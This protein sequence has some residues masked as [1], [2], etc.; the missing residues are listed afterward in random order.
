M[1]YFIFN[2]TLRKGLYI[3]YGIFRT[4]KIKSSNVTRQY[5]KHI[6]RQ[7]NYYYSNPDI[8]VTKQNEDVVLIFSEDFKKSINEELKN[9]NITKQPRKN[10]VGLIAGVITASPCF[11]QDKTNDWLLIEIKIW[12]LQMEII[13]FSRKK[14]IESMTMLLIMHYED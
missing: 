3:M 5:Q 1:K 11:F 8:D 10:A 7:A 6:Q 12:E 14:V 4:N 2:I 9:H 13:L